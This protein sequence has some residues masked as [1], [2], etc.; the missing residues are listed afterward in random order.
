MALAEAET[1]VREALCAIEGFDLPDEPWSV[2]AKSGFLVLGLNSK[3]MPVLAKSVGKMLGCSVSPCARGSNAA[4]VFCD[5]T[6]NRFVL[7][8]SSPQ[9]GAARVPDSARARWSPG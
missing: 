9:D 8:L 3:Q 4:R 7:E 2:S 1:V 6:A 5:A